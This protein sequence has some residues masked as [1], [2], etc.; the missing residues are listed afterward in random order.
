MGGEGKGWSGTVGRGGSDVP[1]VS[2]EVGPM[3]GI[4]E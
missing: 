2:G 1:C 4:W 3:C